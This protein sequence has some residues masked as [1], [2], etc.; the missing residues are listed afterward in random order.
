[1][2]PEPLVAVRVY[3]VVWAGVTDT[4]LPVDSADAIVDRN[5]GRGVARNRPRES[6]GLTGIDGGRRCR[7][8]IHCGSSERRVRSRLNRW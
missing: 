2:A 1:M 6:A 7:E 5:A 4:E 3:V 8:R